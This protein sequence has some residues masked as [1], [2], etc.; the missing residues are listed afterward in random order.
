MR[1]VLGR[2]GVIRLPSL[3]D[4]AVRREPRLDS[5][6]S[7]LL[8]GS[9]RCSRGSI[10]V[11]RRPKDRI[12]G[13]HGR[14]GTIRRI[15]PVAASQRRFSRHCRRRRGWSAPS[16]SI[17]RVSFPADVST[18]MVPFNIRATWR[19][20]AVSVRRLSPNGKFGLPIRTDIRLPS[21]ASGSSSRSRPWPG[22]QL[23]MSATTNYRCPEICT[24]D[25]GKIRPS[26]SLATRPAQ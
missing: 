21:A 23:P 8:A 18:A 14:S 10:W 16:R 9:A 26:S 1:W 20:P 19:L 17:S 12:R 2:S 4:P 3:P 6:V 22:C 15:L 24:I 25:R 13:L 5:S 11:R 7:A